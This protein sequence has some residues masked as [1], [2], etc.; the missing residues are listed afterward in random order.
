[1]MIEKT[2]ILI[3]SKDTKKISYYLDL[4]CGYWSKWER[5]TEGK[6]LYYE[7]VSG[8]CCKSEYNTEGKRINVEVNYGK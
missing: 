2:N 3:E 8:Y 6:T 4:D 7:D 1:M 5:N